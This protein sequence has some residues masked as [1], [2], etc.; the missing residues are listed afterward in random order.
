MNFL[1]LCQRVIDDGGI[2]GTIASVV[3]QSGEFKRVVNWVGEAWRK[4]Q[5]RH[6]TWRWMRATQQTAALTAGNNTLTSASF[7]AT[8]WKWWYVDSFRCYQTAVGVSDEQPLTYWPYDQF[9]DYFLFGSVS[10]G[11]PIVVTVAPDDSLLFGPTPDVDYTIRGDYQKST[12]TLAANGDTPEFDADFHMAIVYRALMFYGAYES[13]NE[14]YGPAEKNYRDEMAR[15][16]SIE[17]P[18]I[19]TL[20]ETLVE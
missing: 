6:E 4:I 10:P 12:Q 3:S 15:I 8:R 1:Q 17:L 16:E 9:R 7:S 5:T 19:Q 13:A 18:R 2:S 14:V 20:V 11:R